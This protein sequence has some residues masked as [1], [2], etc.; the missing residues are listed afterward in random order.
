MPNTY[1][2]LAERATATDV[3]LLTISIMGTLELEVF[4][5]LK[6]RVLA[7]HVFTQ[8]CVISSSTAASCTSQCQSL[9]R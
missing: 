4:T 1:E 8:C 3:E 5:G 9:H 7:M 2:A 6:T